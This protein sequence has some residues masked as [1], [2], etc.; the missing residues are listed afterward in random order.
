MPP[1]SDASSCA[2]QDHT[3]VDVEV[4]PST[5][6][7]LRPRAI[8][9]CGQT[10]EIATEARATMPL[11]LWEP[12]TLARRTQSRRGHKI[13]Y[14]RRVDEHAG[15]L[16][17]LTQR[18]KSGDWGARSSDGRD[19]VVPSELLG[20]EGGVSPRSG[21]K[22]VLQVVD[23]GSR[24]AVV[25]VSRRENQFGQSPSTR[26]IGE[27]LQRRS[28]QTRIL[29]VGRTGVGKS[30]TINSIIGS[31][32][33]S[34][35]HFEPTTAELHFYNGRIAGAPILV[36]DTPGFADTRSDRSNDGKYIDLISRLMGE[37]DL[38]LFVT[39]LDE[40]RVEKGEHDTI[41]VLARNLSPEIWDRS[42][43]LLTRSDR[44]ARSDFGRVLQGRTAV[45]RRAFSDAI[46]DA[47]DSIP[48]IPISNERMRTPDRKHWMGELWLQ[49]LTRLDEH[50][51]QAFAITTLARLSLDGEGAKKTSMPSPPTTKGR[52]PR[53]RSQ[54]RPV[55]PPQ[56][57][58]SPPR[59]G[60]IIPSAVQDNSFRL[61]EGSLMLPS[62]GY[63]L[64]PSN[65]PHESTQ[66]Q[67]ALET[68]NNVVEDLA[69]ISRMWP[70]PTVSGSLQPEI[71]QPYSVES[72]ASVI[73]DE[74][75]EGAFIDSGF[76]VVRSDFDVDRGNNVIV[77][78]QQAQVIGQV[79]QNRAPNL[80]SSLA[81]AGSWIWKRVKN[82]LGMG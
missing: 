3:F 62:Q 66:L 67:P 22:V 45:L 48:F 60:A 78:A 71:V 13:P 40:P 8:P 7:A 61:S 17:S 72:P 51:F 47:A 73:C 41:E 16:A 77:T 24:S 37:I 46:G 82:I 10:P 4:L 54:S 20:K 49:M 23:D 9:C 35:G 36:A 19:Y 15:I 6:L 58:K 42:I 56:P 11:G 80:L 69:P 65:L 57:P 76:R 27:Q 30:S 44:V 68:A 81:A 2:D 59:K 28:R 74:F 18:R 64:S 34:V 38:L 26:S 75:G 14:C 31:L 52:S 5:R 70:T 55:P 25:G 43:V 50:G 1:V 29:V 63:S 21:V 79:I 39:G 53:L 32:V 33:A 12:A